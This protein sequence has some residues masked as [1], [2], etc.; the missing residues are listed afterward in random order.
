MFLLMLFAV[1]WVYSQ[2]PVWTDQQISTRQSYN[3]QHAGNFSSSD[4]I[5]R[6]LAKEVL[7]QPWE[8]GWLMTARIGYEV[9]SSPEGDTLL[10]RLKDL[11]ILGDTLFRSF[12]ITDVLTP[13]LV[14]FGFKFANI[15]DTTGY[16]SRSFS[17][18]ISGR[19]PVHEYKIPVPYFDRRID[20]I[21]FQHIHYTVTEDDWSR[22]R[23]K[24]T[25]I[26][27]YHA[28]NLILDSLEKLAATI[29]LDD[30]VVDI[31]DFFKILEVNRAIEAIRNDDFSNNLLKNSGFDDQF[32]NRDKEMYRMER[33]LTFNFLDEVNNPLAF[34][35]GKT[36]WIQF[37]T[38]R[39]MVWIERSQWMDK[40]QGTIYR[41]V[42]RRMCQG[43][44]FPE[45][46]DVILRMLRKCYPDAQPDTLPAFF[47][48]AIYHDILDASGRLINENNFAEGALLLQC[49]RIF[50]REWN[51]GIDTLKGF[52]MQ[53]RAMEGVF[54]SFVGIAEGCLINGNIPMTDRFLEKAAHYRKQN[55]GYIFN[56]SAYN[57][58]FSRLFFMRNTACDQLLERN[59]FGEALQCYEELSGYYN[60]E[61]LAALSGSL[62]ARMDRAREG[63]IRE[64]LANT[65]AALKRNDGGIALKMDQTV[66]DLMEQMSSAPASLSQMQDTLAPELAAIKVERLFGEAD[67]ALEKRQF[68]LALGL[69]DQTKELALTFNLP[70]PQTFDSLYRRNYK[71]YLMVSLNAAQRKIWNNEFEKAMTSIK[72]TRSA[73]TVQGLVGDPDLDS[74][75]VRFRKKIQE[76]QCRNLSDSVN[77][78]L[79]KAQ[80]KVKSKSY[81]D[82][83]RYFSLVEGLLHEMPDCRIPG[84][85]IIDSLNKYQVPAKYQ[86]LLTAADASV[87]IGHYDEGW[88]KLTGAVEWYRQNNLDPFLGQT[89]IIFQYLTDRNNPYLTL[90]ALDYSILNGTEKEMVDLI[91]LCKDQH[92]DVKLTVSQQKAIGQKLAKS[93]SGGQS[94]FPGMHWFTSRGLTDQYYAALRDAFIR[95]YKET[96]NKIPD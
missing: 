88:L 81:I 87:A 19:S 10:I 60:R 9:S 74:A 14:E 37:F 52:R 39:L 26:H 3:R 12:S 8:I 45:Q 36:D 89:V 92:L 95:K 54:N 20:T 34:C 61:E 2:G 5:I 65:E 21:L 15:S 1:Q 6:E 94:T 35:S 59:S 11:R 49:A 24:L 79:V 30:S 76:Q 80:S 42:M 47:A 71:H 7:K 67:T 48:A 91:R 33:S 75:L 85:S 69:F 32:L 17:F 66:T 90:S 4:L 86:E 18:P 43:I 83:C 29:H 38:R 16:V 31:R 96:G 57:R 77:G 28:S 13:S 62:N 50:A 93:F 58:V 40:L 70:L 25:T 41:E 55:I 63:L 53:S 27:N 22:F 64:A 56:D 51:A 46:P 68:T 73:M 78:Q 82:A 72:E 44:P 23:V 84:V